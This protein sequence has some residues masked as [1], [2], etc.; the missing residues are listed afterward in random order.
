MAVPMDTLLI[1]VSL[2][3]EPKC[4]SYADPKMDHLDIEVDHGK[5]PT[6]NLKWLTSFPI[7]TPDEVLRKEFWEKGVVH[8]KNAMPRELVQDVR[9]RLVPPYSTQSHVL[10]QQY[11]FFEHV[12]PSG[13]LAEGSEPVDGTWCAD[14]PKDFVWPRTDRAALEG[15]RQYAK[16][17]ADWHIGNESA[18]FCE[19]P[20]E[21]QARRPENLLTNHSTHETCIPHATRLDIAI[22]SPPSDLPD[23]ASW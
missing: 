4:S 23:L 13:I 10:I 5:I 14:R 22:L 9:A 8:I 20:R 2:S 21:L 18:A 1:S 15:E 3:A 19:N 16:L 12:S 7:D 6:H 17:A 11:R